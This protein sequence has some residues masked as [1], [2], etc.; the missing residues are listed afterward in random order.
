MAYALSQKW[1]GLVLKACHDPYI[2]PNADMVQYVKLKKDYI[3]GLGDTVDLLVIGARSDPVVVQTLKLLPGSWTTFFLACETTGEDFLNDK[4][5]ARFR[6]VGQVSHPSISL[7]N[8][9]L[10]NMHGRLSQVPFSCDSQRTSIITGLRGRSLP[11]HLFQQPAVAEVVGAEFDRPPN[12][13]YL[14]LR[15]PRVIKIH[16][17]RSVHD[18]VSFAGYQRLAQASMQV[19]NSPAEYGTWLCQLDYDGDDGRDEAA[20]LSRSS[21]P[22]EV[23]SPDVDGASN[24]GMSVVEVKRRRD[25]S[26]VDSVPVKRPKWE[27]AIVVKGRRH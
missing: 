9:H 3:R 4:S 8:L 22:Q 2:D 17:D 15:F 11:S 6:L 12:A 27:T 13:Q 23:R 25:D 10:L 21:S 19:G 14:T 26:F 18:V 20:T 7:T 16:D 24:L 5:R 1:E